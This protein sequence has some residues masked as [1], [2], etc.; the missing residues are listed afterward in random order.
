M[1]YIFITGVNR[2]I[3]FFKTKELLKRG[4]SVIG[5]YRKDSNNNNLQ[6]LK[7]AFPTTLN[8]YS[9]DVQ[10]V[11]KEE[12]TRYLNSFESLDKLINNAGIL[13]CGNVSFEKLRIDDL[14][15]S[16]EVN[17]LGP[18]KITQLLLPKLSES[19][20]PRVFHMTSQMGSIADNQSGGY[21]FYRISKAALNMFNKSFSQDYPHIPSIVIHPGWVRTEMGGNHAPI[22]P[23]IAAINISDLILTANNL[24]SGNFYNYKGEI[25]PW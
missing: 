16:I 15:R 22:S 12:L 23:E 21:Y 3:G 17:T 13:D 14:S 6:K 5:T 20:S 10:A 7:S 24:S 2:G 25:L 18:M 19:A 1:K 8:L 11:E 4:H 9:L